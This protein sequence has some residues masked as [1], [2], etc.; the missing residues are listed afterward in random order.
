MAKNM[1]FKHAE[2]LYID[3]PAGTKSGD[4]VAVGQLVGVAL[5]DADEDGKATIR[6]KGAFSVPVTA[7]DG[8]GPA[9][10]E[11]GDVVYIQAGGTINKDSAGVRFGYALEAVA[12]GE[13]Q[14]IKVKLG[15]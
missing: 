5:T 2:N 4:P 9:A 7:A 14:N 1:V 8:T 10:V 11:L 6:T 15:Y 12:A 13:T 3:V